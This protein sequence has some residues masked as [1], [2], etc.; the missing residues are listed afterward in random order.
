MKVQ[1]GRGGGPSVKCGT[2]WTHVTTVE[3][4]QVSS[5]SE[6]SPIPVRHVTLNREARI[7]HLSQQV[8][9]GTEITFL[10]PR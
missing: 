4:K 9:G 8:W 3:S 10:L 6:K 2:F 5:S 7:R 1:Q